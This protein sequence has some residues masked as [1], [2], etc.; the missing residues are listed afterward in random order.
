M[1]EVENEPIAVIGA[2]VRTPGSGDDLEAFWHTLAE[3]TEAVTTLTD[4]QLAD[5]GVDAATRRLP[6]SVHRSG[7]LADIG[8][9]D[10]EAFG[11][12]PREAELTD[13]QHRLMLEAA[14]VLLERSGHR[15]DSGRTG[16]FAGAGLNYYLLRHLLADPS[17]EDTEGLLPL[18]LANDRDHLAAK[19][20]Y[21]LG[22]T[23]PAM[24]VQTACSTSLVAVHQGVRALQSGDAD[25]VLA[26]GVNVEL[27]QGKGYSATPGSVLSPSG[28]S[29][30]FQDDRDGSVPGNGLGL[31]A[32]RRLDDAI[33]DNDTVLAVI[34]GSAVNNDGSDK[35]GYTSPGYGGQVD[36]LRSA[37]RN[38]GV[39]PSTIGY[40]EGHG[41]GTEVGDDIELAA[42]SEVF[43]RDES[44]QPLPIGSAKATFGNLGAAAGIIGLIKTVLAVRN[45]VLP[46][47]PGD[48]GGF[49]TDDLPDGFLL[50]PVARPWASAPGTPRRA[51]VSS[52]GMGGT[53]CHVVVE[54]HRSSPPTPE[55]DL[56]A[57][58]IPLSAASPEGVV[59]YRTALTEHLTARPGL[60]VGEIARTWTSGRRSFAFRTSVVLTP[61]GPVG[62]S[63]RHT[64][65]Q[66]PRKPRPVVLAFNG[67]ETAVQ[68]MLAGL[69]Q[70]HAVVRDRVEGIL[71]LL[72]EADAA[73]V[74]TVLLDGTAGQEPTA[75][76]APLCLY[77][78][79]VATAELLE[80]LGVVPVAVLGHGG[81]EYA[82]ACCANG[83][84]AVDGARFLAEGLTARRPEDGGRP[85]DGTP[86]TAT[87]AVADGAHGVACRRP[88]RLLVSSSTG[89]AVDPPTGGDISSWAARTGRPARLAEAVRTLSEKVP[90]A[91]VVEIGPGE[92]LSAL[93]RPYVGDAGLSDVVATTPDTGAVA[94]LSQLGRLWSAG[95]GVDLGLANGADG[96]RRVP[97]P[98]Y[99]FDRKRHWIEAPGTARAPGPEG[100]GSPTQSAVRS[101]ETAAPTT[102][103]E[104][105]G[106]L[107][108]VLRAWQETLGLTGIGP[109]ADLYVLG[110][111][112]FTLVRLAARLSR[113]HGLEITAMDLLG[114]DLTPGAMADRIDE[115]SAEAHG[116]AG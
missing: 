1:G 4:A 94:F 38:A 56:T 110:G 60:R 47:L 107:S 109:D 78:A 49:A 48:G 105:A 101:E 62:E 92:S 50:N 57:A 13:P 69:Y 112:S 26:G 82:A 33:A 46:P 59:R 102:E 43:A 3:G 81:G 36:V 99:P 10:A 108:T 70:R 83:F 106:T 74:R 96:F 97:L 111:D 28:R 14:W 80:S 85:G 24:T 29:R 87:K 61:D 104:A 21:R 52:Y 115:L 42:L 39:D 32:L 113:S 17:I 22:L 71:S 34:R 54:E 89:R 12:L 79:Q 86:D 76:L 35:P 72:A 64:P 100:N 18:V 91:L 67:E 16:V 19:I 6:R 53:N 45:G 27:P 114:V 77:L 73:A 5:A 7:V 31:V 20:A 40:L 55:T 68:G 65:L 88:S 103:A 23:G 30:P 116:K 63:L 37:Y 58:V 8:Q 95:V 51:G 44:G 98:T 93:L 9:F 75:D 84:T 15:G 11:M 25:L 41:S 66:V 90:G 2:Y